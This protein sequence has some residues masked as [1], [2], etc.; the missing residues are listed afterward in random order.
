[1]FLSTPPTSRNAGRGGRIPCLSFRLDSLLQF[2]QRWCASVNQVEADVGKG[3]G[4]VNLSVTYTVHDHQMQ[5]QFHRWQS[6]F[7]LDPLKNAQMSSF[8]YSFMR[9]RCQLLVFLCW[10]GPGG[11]LLSASLITCL[12]RARQKGNWR[13]EGR[14]E[15]REE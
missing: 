6:N 8:A 1:M 4:R 11:S 2:T 10:E 13:N 7:S 12:E 14:N 5:V 3:A 15:R 9:S